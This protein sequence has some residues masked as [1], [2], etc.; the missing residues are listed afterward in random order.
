MS[1]P[2]WEHLSENNLFLW[3][4]TECEDCCEHCLKTSTS[5]PAKCVKE[6]EDEL[7]STLSE[8]RRTET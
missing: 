1:N 4:C 3:V 8:E 2:H 7:V 5:R 6:E